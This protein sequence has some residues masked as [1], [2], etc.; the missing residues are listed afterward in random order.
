MINNS[1]QY[2]FFLFLLVLSCD[3]NKFY[4]DYAIVSAKKEAT[5]A[6]MKY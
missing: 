5:L 2:I 3:K 1:Y 6:G 4:N